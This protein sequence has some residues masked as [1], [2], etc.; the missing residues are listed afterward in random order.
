MFW[1]VSWQVGRPDGKDEELGLKVL[2]EPGQHQS[3]PTVLNLQLRSESKEA[4]LQPVAVTSVDQA[5]SNPRKISN[6]IMSINDLHKNEPPPSV[7]YSKQMPEIE[8]L[9]QVR[10]VISCLLLRNWILRQYKHI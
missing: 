7:T 3:D 8:N 2:D 5:D 10:D 6:W 1:R 9:M 4:T